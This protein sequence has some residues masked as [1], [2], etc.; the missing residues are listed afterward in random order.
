VVSHSSGLC[1]LLF[2]APFGLPSCGRKGLHSG[3]INHA[4]SSYILTLGSADIHEP[5]FELEQPG[6]GHIGSLITDGGSDV[7]RVKCVVCC[8]W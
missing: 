4:G 2:C 7:P 1:W 8:L 6:V 5:G 3:E